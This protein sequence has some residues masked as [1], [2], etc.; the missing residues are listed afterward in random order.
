MDSEKLQ[1][2]SSVLSN[3]LANQQII[4]WP[5]ANSTVAV[6]FPTNTNTKTRI[7]GYG[8]Y[9]IDEHNDADNDYLTVFNLHDFLAQEGVISAGLP[10]ICMDCTS[11]E[12]DLRLEM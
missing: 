4:K 6:T 1:F 2:V 9:M 3:D 12:S 5:F 8:S 11:P 7:Q 10:S